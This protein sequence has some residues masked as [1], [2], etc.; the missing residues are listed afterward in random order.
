MVHFWE[1]IKV[2]IFKKNH[3]K[4]R[5]R[6]FLAIA[7]AFSKWLQVFNP[8]FLLYKDVRFA[9]KNTLSSVSNSGLA[10]KGLSVCQSLFLQISSLHHRPLHE[11]QSIRAQASKSTW[12]G[13]TS[14]HIIYNICVTSRI[15]LN[16]T[17]SQVSH[18]ENRVRNI[19][20]TGLVWVLILKLL[21]IA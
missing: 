6:R 11:A 16:F 4:I 5:Q 10:L 9:K 7:I 3:S 8:F 15:L 17:E 13:F 20:N 19:L 18:P 12:P 14:C 1:T 21:Y 2:P